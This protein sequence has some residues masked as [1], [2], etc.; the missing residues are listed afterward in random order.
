MRVV[1]FFQSSSVDLEKEINQFL[2]SYLNIKITK[3]IHQM[4]YDND[5]YYAWIYYE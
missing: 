2:G 1:R 3:I 4:D 5:V